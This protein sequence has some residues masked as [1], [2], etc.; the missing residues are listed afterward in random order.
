M[1][2]L[3]CATS[4]DTKFGIGK[5]QL[6]AYGISL[7]QTIIDIDEIQ[8]EDLETI[9]RDKV[10]KAF[11]LVGKPI[12]VTDDSWTISAL[13]GFPGP[14][15]KSINHWFTPDDFIRLTRDLS[16]RRIYLNQLVAYQ[17]EV[18]TVVFRSDIPGE[19]LTESRGAYGVP[20][21]KV[22]TLDGDNGLTISE[23]YDNNSQHDDER[24]KRRSDAWME[25]AHGYKR[26]TNV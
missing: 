9:I 18:E 24:L 2:Q 13:G 23:T 8:S 17:D 1:K 22:V 19:L 6:E 7:E 14:Y 16:D 10:G 21:M 26:K 5:K 20:C 11:A 15:M 12:V 3:L 4:N 25:L